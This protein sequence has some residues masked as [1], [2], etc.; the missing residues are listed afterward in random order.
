MGFVL[1]LARCSGIGSSALRPRLLRVCDGLPVPVLDFTAERARY[2]AGPPDIIGIHPAVAAHLDGE[3]SG[4]A[5]IA[6]KASAWTQLRR[7]SVAAHRDL[8]DNPPGEI[9]EHYGYESE[10]AGRAVR[11][12]VGEG[13]ALL[14]KLGA[15]PWWSIAAAWADG[16]ALPADLRGGLPAR[17]W[18]LPRVEATFEAW[19]TGSQ[20]PL[21]EHARAA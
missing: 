21:R 5:Q 9:A 1:P 16:D 14:V 17:W 4:A 18:E 10:D 13:R 12:D 8:G 2:I 11:R 3:R 6:A 20:R 19:R 7:L 15:W